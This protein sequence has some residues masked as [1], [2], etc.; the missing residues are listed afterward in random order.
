MIDISKLFRLKSTSYCSLFVSFRFP[1]LTLFLL[2][3]H[4]FLF[5]IWPLRV[6]SCW[7]IIL[8]C[9]DYLSGVESLI[10]WQLLGTISSLRHLLLIDSDPLLTSFPWSSLFLITYCIRSS[11]HFLIDS[12]CF[13]L[14]GLW[15]LALD[16][17]IANLLPFFL[18]VV[19]AHAHKS[20]K[21]SVSLEKAYTFCYTIIPCPC[22]L[23]LF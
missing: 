5:V 6:M 12:E 16:Q 14:L 21:L 22:I 4:L 3:Y 11:A 17:V 1:V 9:I 20:L 19:F 10:E 23:L 7:L 18:D 8:I 13:L 15:E 2:I